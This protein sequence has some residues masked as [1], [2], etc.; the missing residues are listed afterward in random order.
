MK[1]QQDKSEKLKAFWRYL[2]ASE[3]R[4]NI[5]VLVGI[6]IYLTVIGKLIKTRPDHIFFA[7]MIFAFAVLGKKWG[8]MLL[9]DWAP[10]IFF[11]MAY[12]M[13]RGVADTFRSTINIVQPYEIEKS[14]FGWLTPAD[15]PAFYFQSW[16]QLHESSFLKT[17][18]DVFTSN[19]YAIHFPMPLIIGWIIWHTL[20]DRRNYYQLIYTLTV[21]NFMALVTFMLYPAAPPWYV[22]E[23]GFVQPTGEF[24]EA[25]GALVNFDKLIGSNVLRSIWNTFNSNKFAAIPSLHSGYPSAIALF[26]WLRFG[27]KH[28]LWILYPAAAWFSAVYLNHHYIIDLIIGSLYAFSAYAF[29]KYILI[30]KLFDRIVNFDLGSKEILVVQRNTINPQDS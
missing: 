14:L 28:W 8:K 20:N 23:H 10:W 5:A 30:P 17:F 6:A 2:N 24:L 25:A 3:Q 21:L 19:I 12:D 16:Q 13:M 18:F 11:W 29:T 4:F 27:G 26:M 9:T 22:F 7:L 1:K 15:I